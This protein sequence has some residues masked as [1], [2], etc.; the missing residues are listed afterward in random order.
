VNVFKLLL[1]SSRRTAIFAL[2]AGLVGGA[3][4]VGLVALIQVALNRDDVSAGRLAAGFVGLCL[5]VLLTRA[6]SQALLI[7]LAQHSVFRLYTQLSRAM[8][9]IPLRQFETI[10]SHRLLA[11]LTEDVPAI[12]GA[13]VGVPIVCVNAAILLC[14]LIYL[15]WLSPPLLLGV[16]GFLAVGVL[17]Y[18]LLVWKA[19]GKLHLARREHDTLMKH[20]RGLTGGVKELQMHRGRRDE[21]LDQ[22]LAGTAARLRDRTTAG[23][24]LYTFAGTCGQLLFFVCIG[25]LL[26]AV[27]DPAQFS[28]SVTS[29]YV[30]T[31]L[32]AAAPVETIM[33][34]LPILGRARVA[35]R[36]VE[37]LNLSLAQSADVGDGGAISAAK[38]P[39][40]RHLQLAGVTHSYCDSENGDDGFVLGPIDLTLRRGELVFVVGGNGSGKTT[41]ARLVVGLYPPSAGAIRLN[42]RPIGDAERD[43]YR[44]LFSA[45]FSDGY[46]FEHVSGAGDARADARARRYLR[47]LELDHK[48]RVEGGRFSTT[49][50]SQGQRKRLALLTAYLE[51]RPVYVFDEWACDQDP[52]FRKVF[53]ARLLPELKARGKAVLVISHDDRYF[54]VADRIVKLEY[55]T[56]EEV[57]SANRHRPEGIALHRHAAP[58]LIQGET[59]P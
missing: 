6:A 9:A 26:F 23:M 39:R 10:G 36:A 46:L 18:Q 54:H 44:E 12:A 27:A 51:D 24:S 19:L 2:A 28:R 21:F 42:G 13:L 47:R 58:S 38:S 5:A 49:D 8:L 41:L 4:G 14:C 33:T 56:L 48:V 30:L 31:I 1:R 32:Y 11:A 3:A 53:Y 57:N 20:F 22:L 45:V 52:Y 59:G 43:H 25:L 17:S 37:E 55:G 35:L 15:G 50:L 34:W 40:F 29:G 16:L 7:R